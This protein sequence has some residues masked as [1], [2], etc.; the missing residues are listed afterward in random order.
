[1]SNERLENRLN[2]LRARHRLTQ[3]ALANQVGVARQTIVAIEKGDYNPSLLLAF[4]IAYALGVPI[5]EVFQY[6]PP[7]PQAVATPDIAPT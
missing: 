1:M 3:Q 5:D 6:V 7:A 4:K 2:E